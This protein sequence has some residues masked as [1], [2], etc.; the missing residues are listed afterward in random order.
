VYQGATPPTLAHT[1]VCSFS[2]QAAQLKQLIALPD[3]NQTP[4]QNVAYHHDL[5]ALYSFFGTPGLYS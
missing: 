2:T 4:V 3:A 1:T 5:N